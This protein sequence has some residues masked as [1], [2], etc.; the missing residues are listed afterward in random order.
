MDNGEY[1]RQRPINRKCLLCNYHV[2]IMKERRHFY[3]IGMNPHATSKSN[4]GGEEC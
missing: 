1:P 3:N 2:V 4:D